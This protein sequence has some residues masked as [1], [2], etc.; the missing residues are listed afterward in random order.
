MMFCLVWS[1]TP[2]ATA[3]QPPAIEWH[4]NFDKAI[5][6]AKEL[7][8]PVIM[9]FWASWCGPCR[10]MDQEVWPRAEVVAQSQKFVCISV[11]VDTNE[12]LATR[13]RANPIPLIV[14]ADPWGNEITRHV[15]YLHA[16]SLARVM[17]AFP[18]D[19]SGLNAWNAVLERDSKNVEALSGVAEFYRTLNAWDLSNRY[20]E[21][22][23]KTDAAK[24]NPEMKEAF[25]LAM[26]LN[27]LKLKDYKDA[28]KTFEKCLKEVPNG[29]RCATALLGLVTAHIGQGKIAE[30]EKTFEQ[31]Q[32]QYPDSPATRQAAQ[33]LQAVKGSQ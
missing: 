19:F 32:S 16:S 25:L 7:G 30:A 8:K 29:S 5:K 10:Q 33:N 22:A 12:A 20:Y 23:L 26:G 31:L 18:S 24:A 15:G 28:R 4:R 11:D 21:R 6:L 3:S 1:G 14:F 9:D 27:C 13:F 2:G 17:K